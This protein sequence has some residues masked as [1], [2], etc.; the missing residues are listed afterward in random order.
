M[1]G[2]AGVAG[3]AGRVG[4]RVVVRYRLPGGGLTDAL[5]DLLAADGATLLVRTRRGDVRVPV[6]D[7]VTGKVV[8]PRAARPGPPHLALSVTDQVAVMAQHWGA[9]EATRFGGWWVRAAGGFTGRAN[10]LVPLGPPDRDDDAA[11]AAVRGW[12]A[13]RG[14]PAL[15]S[16]ATAVPGGVPVAPDAPAA[17]AREVLA[18]R[19]WQVVADASA[20]VLVA[21]TAELR[22]GPVPAGGLVLDAAPRPDAAWLATY[23]Y[24]G[25]PLPPPALGVLL[26]APEQR[27]W[28]VRDGAATV[29][30]ARG[31]LAA[32]W[33]GVTAVDVAPAY[34]RRGLAR[35]LL[36]AV[37]RWAW[38]RGALSTYLQ[39]AE[40]NVAA[41]ALYTSSGFVLHHRYDYL[42]APDRP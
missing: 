25:L 16:A 10:C 31:S 2:V 4:R 7:V 29:A 42:R 27:F 3:W 14:L 24:R 6:A 23:R 32:G 36:T 26:S 34:R 13:A 28:S 20:L 8:P 9:P 17:H 1:D 21:P 18:A 39:T 38:Q 5:G 33:A 37:A 35:A 15:A 11:E 22:A 40:S 19:G 30:V 12:Y 41:Q